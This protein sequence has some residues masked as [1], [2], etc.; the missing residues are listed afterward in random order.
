MTRLWDTF[1]SGWE[2][3]LAES[4]RM[5]NRALAL[6]EAETKA[7]ESSRRQLEESYALLRTLSEQG[8]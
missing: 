4:R 8:H 7:I 2:V 3:Q 1:Q 6:R 5:F